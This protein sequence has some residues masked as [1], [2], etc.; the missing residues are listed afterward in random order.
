M[1]AISLP[2]LHL[3]S[4]TLKYR[5]EPPDRP[6]GRRVLSVEEM[7]AADACAIAEQRVPGIVLMEH[8]GRHL[9]MAARELSTVADL[10]VVLTGGGNNGGDGYSAARHLMSMGRQVE[11]WALRERSA[12]DGDTALAASMAEA[13]GVIIREPATWSG[14][15]LR[16]LAKGT[17]LIDAL[18][19]TGLKENVRARAA[20]LIRTV[21]Q[22]PLVVI[23]ADIP[24]GVCG[25]SGAVLGVAIE[26][27]KTITFQASKLGH[28]LYPGAGCVGELCIVDIGMPDVAMQVMSVNRRIADENADLEPVFEDVDANSHKGRNGHVLVIGG[29]LGRT[30]AVRM[31]ADAAMVAGAGLVTVG[32]SRSALASLGGQAYEIMACALFDD[33]AAMDWHEIALGY[34]AVVLGPGLPSDASLGRRLLTTL[35]LLNKP[36]VLDA[37]GLN[38]LAMKGQG[39]CTLEECVI[40]PHPGEAGRLLGCSAQAI[41]SDRVGAVNELVSR[42]DTTVVLKGAHTLI[43]TRHRELI[44]CGAGNVGM[45]TAGTGDVLAGVIG[46]L[47]ARGL[48]PNEAAIGGVLWHA[49]AGDH[50]AE[51]EGPTGL[52]ARDILTGLR[53]VEAWYRDL[54]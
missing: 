36:L 4:V 8:A 52:R 31:A 12:L 33:T 30:G 13:S 11:V 44:I 53:G 45:A 35:H 43:G 46:A 34:D 41:Q 19:G 49:M 3:L 25:D 6:L 47:L 16:T 14:Q 5:I 10:C 26:A 42:Y 23:A 21:N 27:T 20:E 9:A 50:S 18:M 51:K 24:S 1:K 22:L 2:H 32:T 40:T 37:D 17:I 15:S 38:H 28:W 54:V 29:M 39:G 48:P 7:R